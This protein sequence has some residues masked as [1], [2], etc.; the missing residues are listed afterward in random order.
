MT[1]NIQS[2]GGNLTHE[3]CMYL[4]SQ[5]IDFT[6]LLPWDEKRYEY[7]SY[8]VEYIL[9][10]YIFDTRTPKI[11]Q[12]LFFRYKTDA[13]IIH[14]VFEFP[15]TTV[16]ERI[17]KQNKKPLLIGLAGTY[18]V[19]PL[20][21][22]PDS[23]LLKK[24][25]NHASYLTAISQFTA[26]N[27]VKYSGTKTPMNIIHCA[28]NFERFSKSQDITDLKK[29]YEGKKVLLT[30][31]ALKPRK[32]HD[33][34]L[35]ALTI[36]KKERND[37]HY[38]IIGNNEERSLYMNRLT[39]L[40]EKGNLKDNVT[41][42]GSVSND[43]LPKYYQ[44]CDMYVH[45]PVTTNWNFEGFG[46]VYLEAGSAHK[47]VVASESGGVLDAVI[48]NKTGLV[49]PEGD[50]DAT[51]KAIKNIMDDEVLAKRLGDGGFEY[52]KEHTWEK[53]GAKFVEL[54]RVVLSKVRK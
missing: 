9:P 46:I 6:L 37:F 50:V 10:S 29:K 51:Y 54:Y 49:V 16:A 15:Y 7:S 40:I 45:V 18:A 31:G 14:S 33:I 48:P 11:F 3:L 36:L 35:Q 4:K 1:N 42:A 26:D 30:I 8:K 38:I 24:A 44:M 52:A 47:P 5:S 20:F 41:F 53:I 32:G 17:S 21:F 12:Y 23:Y 22:F 34:V 13:D 25:Y 19:K 28:V 39:D 43:D 27:V 2:G